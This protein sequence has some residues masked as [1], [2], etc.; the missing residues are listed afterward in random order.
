[1]KT[2][3]RTFAPIALL[4][5]AAIAAPA[6]AEE[7]PDLLN[8]VAVNGIKT[9]NRIGTHSFKLNSITMNGLSPARAGRITW[10]DIIVQGSE[11]RFA[12]IIVQG[13]GKRFQ[14]RSAQPLADVG[15][16]GTN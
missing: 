14:N 2:I 13:D 7:Q 6:H 16:A 15:T 8:S 12:S 5:A 3:A 4:V 1:M 11:G 9:Q 10:S